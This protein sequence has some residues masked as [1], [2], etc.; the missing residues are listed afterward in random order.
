MS[1]KKAQ[2]KAERSAQMLAP[3]IKLPIAFPDPELIIDLVNAGAPYKTITAVQKGPASDNTPGWFRNFWALGGK[4]IFPGAAELF[5]NP[6]FIDAAKSSFSAQVIRP[7]AMMTNLNTPAAASPVHLDLPF[8][9]GAHNREV[10][11]W[12][13]A[14]M[15]YSGL[16]Q[17]WAIPVAS[18]ISWFYLG[19]GGDFEYWPKGLAHPSQRVSS[20]SYNQAVVADNEYMYHRVGE[21]GSPEEYLSNGIPS[22]ALL[23]RTE[24]GW[25]IRQGD[26]VLSSYVEDKIRVSILWKAF[27]FKDQQDAEAFNDPA[28]NLTPKQIVDIFCRDLEAQ[29][30]NVTVPTD[31]ETDTEFRRV[32]MEH[33]NSPEGSAY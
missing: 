32:V 15:G 25:E 12:L 28:H 33:Y 9:R 24:A 27:C 11:S 16:F 8:F 23:H 29:N 6:A 19:R 5:H 10:P 14:P 21:M 22:T 20:P 7:L 3:P 17:E 18:A 2:Q 13:L 26:E 4:V 1:P 30:I 31:L